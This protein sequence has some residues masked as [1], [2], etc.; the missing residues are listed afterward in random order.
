MGIYSGFKG[1]IS[2]MYLQDLAQMIHSGLGG[3]QATRE[4]YHGYRGVAD[5][6]T[7]N[8]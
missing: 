2:A 6:T 4:T 7:D 8:S 5:R 3:C 1:A